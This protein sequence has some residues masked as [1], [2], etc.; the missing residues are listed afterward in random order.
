MVFELSIF[1]NLFH[2]L[3]SSYLYFLDYQNLK[4][5][6]LLKDGDTKAN[7]SLAIKFLTT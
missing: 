2:K 4:V 3:E 6:F 1:R 7:Y 5:Y